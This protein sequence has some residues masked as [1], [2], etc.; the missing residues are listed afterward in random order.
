[1][2]VEK[3]S[4]LKL[5]LDIER[6]PTPMFDCSLCDE[7]REVWEVAYK[8]DLGTWLC[9][10]CALS[11]NTVQG[12]NYY[13]VLPWI[14]QRGIEIARSITHELENGQRYGRTINGRE[15]ESRG[16]D[17]G[18]GDGLEGSSIG[19]DLGSGSAREGRAG[20]AGSS[21]CP[22]RGDGSEVHRQPSEASVARLKWPC[23]PLTSKE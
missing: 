19:E 17:N 11:L 8:N 13:R 12:P 3:L 10:K 7:T 16:T 2:A 18:S 23:S 20:A 4:K 14:E 1:M 6:K 15:L 22:L 9:H 5:V 21:R